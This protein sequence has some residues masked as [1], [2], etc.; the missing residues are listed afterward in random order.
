MVSEKAHQRQ[1]DQISKLRN[2]LKEM[3][4]KLKTKETEDLLKLK[5][6]NTKFKHEISDLASK[7]EVDPHLNQ[8]THLIRMSVDDSNCWKE[9]G[10]EKV[11]RLAR[12]Q[13]DML[14]TLKHYK[15]KSTN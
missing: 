6:D 14:S 1:S 8:M 9:N 15:Q 2:Q 10:K 5:D 3:G 12:L 4:G 13:Q 11:G 7:L